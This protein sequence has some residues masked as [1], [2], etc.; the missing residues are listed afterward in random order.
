MAYSPY[1]PGVYRPTFRRFNFF[2]PVIRLLILTNVGVYLFQVFVLQGFLTVGGNSL[3]IV[4]AK[5]FYLW[6]IGGGFRPWQLL[7]YMFLHGGFV[8]LFYNMLMLWMF[9]IEVENEW[10]TRKFA[11]FYLACGVA[12]GLANLFFAPLF[13]E[14]APTIGASGGVYGVLVAFAM[15]FPNRYVYF[16]FFI[17]IRAKYLMIFLIALEAYAGIAGTQ[18][19][20]AH[21]AHLGGAL[22]AVLW[23]VMDARGGDRVP[24][25]H[26][27]TRR[28]R[29]TGEPIIEKPIRGTV[30]TGLDE[31]EP[32]PRSRTTRHDYDQRVIDDILDKISRFGYSGLT[33]EEKRILL[34]ASRRMHSDE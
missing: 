14:P 11:L 10:G 18:E 31:D 13:T 22:F 27:H 1:D 21:I 3:Q 7:T 29:S 15:L 34:D 23:M 12:A 19:G 4:F 25:F 20:I 6:P 17:P 5:L 9:G 8:H 16:Y 33:E 30:Y 32:I 2:P 26:K 24:W 28:A